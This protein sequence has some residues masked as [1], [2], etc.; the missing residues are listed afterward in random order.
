[1]I[2]KRFGLLYNKAMREIIKNERHLVVENRFFD[3]EKLV[4]LSPIETQNYQIIQVTDSYYTATCNIALHTQPCDLEITYMLYNKATY[5]ADEHKGR[6]QKNEVSLL[7]RDEAHAI[8]STNI[9]RFQTLA[10][11]VKRESPCYPLFETVKEY[12]FPYEKRTMPLAE[13]EPLLAALLSDFSLENA[14]H[15]ELLLDCTITNIL[16]KLLRQTARTAEATIPQKEI[17]PNIMAFLDE[18][19]LKIVSLR[20]VAEH[21]RYSYNYLCKIFKAQYNTTIQDYLISKKMNYAKRL[22]REKKNVNEISELLNYSNPYNFSRSFK[23][24]YGKSPTNYYASSAKEQQ[25]PT[26]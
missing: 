3:F 26:E 15:I 14:P 13:I 22:L 9:C 16:V 18:N 24:Y 23:N 20:E 19:F 6:M 8:T 25:E 7:F 12:Y 17:L 11:N 4:M 2:D 5:T 10:F 1:M 21:F